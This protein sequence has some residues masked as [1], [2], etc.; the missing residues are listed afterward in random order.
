MTPIG[1]ATKSAY[2]DK[3]WH[4]ACAWCERKVSGMLS[5]DDPRWSQLRGGYRRP[6]DPRKPLLSLERGTDVSA[7]WSELWEELHHQGDVGEASYAAVPHLVRIHGARDALEGNTYA[8]AVAIERA[9]REPANPQMPSWL[10]AA[11][12]DAWQD[13]VDLGLRD[14][15]LASEDDLIGPII[16]A[17]SYGKG[18]PMLGRLAM[19]TEQE[20]GQM[21]D[22][23]GWG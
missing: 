2:A 21:L 8:L 17:L 23:A 3:S 7:A 10:G 15:R 20:R 12:D 18:L 5:F 1:H 4:N 6:Y 22:E 14:L 9:R 11:Y 13:L 19:L 16:A